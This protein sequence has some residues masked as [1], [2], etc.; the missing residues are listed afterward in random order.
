MAEALVSFSIWTMISLILLPASIYINKERANIK[1]NH[2]ALSVLKEHI[3]DVEFDDSAKEKQ[4]SFS[5]DT[6]FQ[7]LW[8]KEGESEH[9]C[10]QRQ[11]YVDRKEEKCL[12]YFGE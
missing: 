1:L 4:G 6:K 7:I 2:E 9:A 5:N 8:K 12:Y 10:I 11:D 3:E